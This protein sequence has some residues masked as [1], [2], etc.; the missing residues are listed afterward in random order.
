[1]PQKKRLGEILIEAGV[2]NE[3]QLERALHLQ[4]ESH[5]L[6]GQILVEMGWATEQEVCRAVAKVLNMDYVN[7]DKALISQEVVQLIPESLATKYNVLPLF[8]QNKTLYL[9]MEN[10][11]DSDVIKYLEM[12]TGMHIRSLI[13]PPIQLREAVR[14]H[15]S[16]EEYVKGL[17]GNVRQ[18]EPIS[19]EKEMEVS[20]E[21]TVR[22]DVQTIGEEDQIVRLVSLILA[23]GIKERAS[24]IQIKSTSKHVTLQYKI[25]GI[26]TEEILLP[27]WLQSPLISAIKE[28]SGM[29]LAEQDHLQDGRFGLVYM[30]RKIDLLVSTV[31]TSFG[32]NIVIH[33]LDQKTAF[34]RLNRLGLSSGHQNLC[35]MIIHQPQGWI[36]V[37]GPPGCGKTTTLYALLKAMKDSTKKIVTLENPVEYQL[38]G[39]EQF[40]VNPRVE[41]VFP[42]GL[43]SLLSQKLHVIFIGEVR[44]AETA[45][46]A[47]QASETGHLVLSPLHASDA[48]ST[49]RRLLHLGISPDLLAFNLL[50]VIAQR[51]VRRICPQ[52]KTKHV[53]T[54]QELQSIGFHSGHGPAFVCYRGS[55]CKTCKHTGYYGQTGIYEILTLNDRLREEILR[56]P[57]KRTLKQLA[58]EAGME[59]IL[60][61]GIKKIQQGIT[62]IEEVA[63]VCA[64]EPYESEKTIRCPGCGKDIMEN[65]N[66]CPFCRSRLCEPC[67]QCGAELEQEWLVCPFCGAQKWEA[68]EETLPRLQ[69]P[70]TSIQPEIPQRA[71]RIVVVENDEATRNMI[72][73]LLRQQGYE[74]YTAV[75]EEVALEQIRSKRPELVILATAA[76]QKNGFSICKALRSSVDTMFIPTL[77]LTKRDSVEEKLQGLSLGVNNYLTKPFEPDELL[78]RIEFV[79]RR[80]YQQEKE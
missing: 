78:T 15:C 63:R 50:V 62:T 17:L 74:V 28:I 64:V 69:Q 70:Q 18:E 58:L 8:I 13:A 21:G 35:R 66:I 38:D 19:I 29:D 49:I 68:A 4:Q 26:L 44:D 14:R 75:H 34:H 54:D 42:R 23:Y 65:E 47:V 25:D 37:T 46:L 33:I 40:Q 9:A 5:K 48:V 43:Q 53:P 12:N 24:D 57:K 36:V 41:Q 52:C 56:Y 80:S 16:I 59:T 31:F 39:I 72:T 2:I 79:L 51:L 1:M 11:L 6:L 10:S 27:K 60:E 73:S 7:V 22:S 71:V 30:H 76:P 32:E 77:M 61:D 67:E 20:E 3:E 55:G 45:T